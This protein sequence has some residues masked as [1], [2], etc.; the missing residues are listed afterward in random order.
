MKKSLLQFTKVT[1][2]ILLLC[3]TFSCQ[4][5]VV[6]GI[7]EEAKVLMEQVDKVWSEGDLALVEKVY[8]SELI[9]HFS[10]QPED[11]VGLES[12]KNFVKLTR[13]QLHPILSSS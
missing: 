13:A 8:S 11:I 4:K 1:P 5:Q 3:F 9:A 2:V 7:T 6:E 12:F 10:G